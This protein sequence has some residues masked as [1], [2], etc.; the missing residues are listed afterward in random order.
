MKVRFLG[1]LLVLVLVAAACGAENENFVEVGAADAAKATRAAGNI[2]MA[3]ANWSSGYVQAQILHDVLEE[4]GY[5]VS[6]PHLLEFA[7]DLG[8]QVLASGQADVWA[9]TWNPGHEETWFQG[10]LPDGSRIGDHLKVFDGSLMPGGGCLLYT[11]PSPRD[12][13]R[14]RMPSS[15]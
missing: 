13:T 15:A 6:S 14:S 2:S 4:L 8:Y 1:T 7:P 5:N 9:N 3:R 12:R 10:Q 11:S